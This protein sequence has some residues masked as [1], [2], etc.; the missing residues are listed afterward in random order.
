MLAY[1][2]FIAAQVHLELVLV[3][4]LAYVDQGLP[5]EVPQH[6]VLQFEQD[7][8]AGGQALVTVRLHCLRRQ[9]DEHVDEEYLEC[10]SL[11]CDSLNQVALR[12]LDHLPERLL[13]LRRAEVFVGQ[14]L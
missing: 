7:V 12:L 14:P 3:N 11:T 2:D 4:A 13:G 6:F 8:L 9:V 1:L 5:T 10:E